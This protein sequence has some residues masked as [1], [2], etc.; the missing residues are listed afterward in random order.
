MVRSS[1]AATACSELTPPTQGS[2]FRRSDLDFNCDDEEVNMAERSPQTL[3]NHVRLDPPF[4]FF[5]LPVFAISWILSVVF[6]VR[7]FGFLHCWIAVVNTAILVAVIRFRE[8][9]LKVQDRVIR[10]EERLRLAA[11][12]SESLCPQI[13]KLSEGQLIAL[14]FASDEEVPAL[15]ERTLSTNL[16]RAD[17]KKAILHWRPDYWRV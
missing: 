4:H 9:A 13:A 8:Y 10:L 16:S 7:H 15:V 1:I 2:A 6:L 14:R 17:I 5:V 3:A 11:L 12:L